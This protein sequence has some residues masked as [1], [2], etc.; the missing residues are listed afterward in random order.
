MNIQNKMSSRSDCSL[1]APGGLFED[2][3]FGPQSLRTL[4]LNDYIY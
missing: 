1:P 3:F 2:T 4:V